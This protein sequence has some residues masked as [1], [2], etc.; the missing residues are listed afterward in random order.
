M[1]AIPLIVVG[2][3]LAVLLLFGWLG[4]R[5]S[6]NSE[7]DYYLAGRQQGWIISAMTI[8]AT[9]FSSFALLGAPGM[10]YR[11][12]VVFALV[13]LNVPV[14]GVCI[15]I[16]GNRIRKAGLA[17]GYVTQADMLCDHYQ[18]PVVLRILITLVGFLFAIPYVMMQL[19]A[20]GELAAVL[21]RDQPHAFEWGAIILSFITA[22]YIMIGGMRSVAWTDALQCFLLTSG[23]IMGGVAL[24]VSMGGPAAF[25]DQ[26]SR[27]PAA[28]LTVPGNTGFWQVPM[29]FSVCLLMP[30]GGIIQPAQWMRFYSARDANT[31]RRS[32]LIFT[33]LL[34][35]CFVF[36]IMPIGLGGQVMYPLSYSANGVAPHPHVGNY[37]QILVVILGDI[38]PKMVGG[39]V[40]MTLT[41]LLVVAIMAA[42]MSTADSNLHALSALFTRDL[43]GR[44]F[45][46]RASERERV[47][48]G[49][50][51]ILLATAASLILVLIGS[52]PESSLAG[53]MQMIVGLALFA[54]AFSVQLLPMTIDVL[55]VRRGT[56]LAAICG[57]VSGLVVAFCFTSLFPPMLQL[58]PESTSSSLSGVIDQAKALAPIHASAWGLIA[59]T[60][61]FVLLSA[62]SRKQLASILFVVTLSASVLPAQAIDLA[63][64]DSF[65]AKPKI[66][67]HYMPWFTAKPF[68]D[69]WG[70]HW[71]MNHFDPETI[72]GEKRQIASTSYP[73]I[74][75]YDS[76]DP[77][78][79]E[80]HLLLMKL[81]GIEGVIVDWYGLTDLNDY[82]QLHRNTTRL[83]QQCE[84]MQMKFVI[85]YEDQTI[86]ALVAAHRIS[87]SDKVSH[88]VK[89]LEW[90]NRYWFQS[91]SYLKQEGKPVL[92]SFGHAGLSKQEWT[93]CLNKLSFEPNYFSQDFR[94]EGASGAF[95]WPAPRIGL[96]QVDRF[97]AES[98]NWPQA[99][100]AAFPRFDDIYREAGIG[101]GYPVLPDRAGKTFQETLQKA[102]DSRQLLIQLVT[103]NDWGEGTQIEP[104]LEYGYRDL[105][106]LQNFRR[107]R[108]D[109]SFEPQAKDIELPLK[110]LQLR[111]EQPDQQKTLDEVVAQLLAGKIPQARELLSSLL[112]E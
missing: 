85:C 66:L 12:G 42:A 34:T 33:I 96:K 81:A 59:N 24:L 2:L 58:L 100:P 64:E 1:S 48:A 3:Y 11:E 93:D 52:R 47:W 99:I 44:F 54:V 7:E 109:S 105:E 43:Y 20:G 29:L 51:V 88:A 49:Q 98:Q 79:L 6:S 10:V 21:F 17:G 4:Y 87:E 36:A 112:P 76:G 53:F 104:S 94:R 23:M 31:L 46:P 55:F 90:L 83:L 73:L 78:V 95:G 35:G 89:E 32:A 37:D 102:T 84:R 106:F 16:F 26:V 61:V 108:F 40:G 65:E 97:L 57:L 91:G 92:L 77:Q 22:L 15:A 72:I 70:W 50:I 27:L 30:I 103:W 111:R 68:S 63:K 9:F 56:K 101:E 67:A 82:A 19:K 86:P 71:T 74:G 41:S 5:C 60:I 13:S 28:S 18:S 14:A 39:T 45:R 38:L 107:E 25:L 8:M 80:Y 69:H 62:F 110:I 75:P